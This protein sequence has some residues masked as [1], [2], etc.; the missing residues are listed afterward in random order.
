M[1]DGRP[2]GTPGSPLLALIP[3]VAAAE[4]GA[5]A[6]LDVKAAEGLAQYA[7]HWPGRVLCLSRSGD[8][9]ANAYGRWY[10]RADLPFAVRCIPADAPIEAA[11]PHLRSAALVVAGADDHRDQALP[12]LLPG[13]PVVMTIEY[14]LRTRLDILRLEDLPALRKLR[15]AAWL[16]RREPRLRRALRHAAGLQANGTP[17]FAAYAGLNS[18]PLLFFDTRLAGRDHVGAAGV[19]AKAAAARDRTGP[20]RLAFSGRL[21][22][23]K[24]AD[25]LVPV[26]AEL[27]RLGRDVTLDIYGQGSLSAPIQA[28]AA[29][30]GL[31]G[32]VRL[33]GPVP[34][35]TMLVPSLR[36]GADLFLC[37][38]PQAD[39][40]CT[41]L[42]TLGCGVP[43]AGFLNAAFRGVLELGP[44]GVGAAVGDVRG[45]A[46][47]IAALDADRAALDR[48]SRGAADVSA[49]RTFEATMAQRV[50]HLRAVAGLD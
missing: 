47:R 14:T 7:R 37:P 28:D 15:T 36:D 33:H 30:L 1:T 29:R 13:I 17:A 24:G 46:A 40:S 10:D 48:L 8:P 41:Y 39:P 27:V 5:R 16:L 11:L 26:M 32:R 9:A 19:E 45:L 6:F 18:H 20:L 35:D 42:E 21:E 38:H 43:I 44:C 23:M 50:A 2:G 34:F 49:T 4:D 25:R 12:G 22:R 3:N 31:D